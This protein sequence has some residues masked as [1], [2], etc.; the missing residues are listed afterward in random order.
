[1]YSSQ[2]LSSIVDAADVVTVDAHLHKKA[3]SS[4]G[5]PL[6]VQQLVDGNARTLLLRALLLNRSAPQA[7]LP[8]LRA[9]AV[10]LVRITQSHK[11]IVLVAGSAQDLL[12]TGLVQGSGYP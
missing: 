8:Y 3:L 12:G 9:A 6:C 2:E 11:S 4:H 10:A 7:H 1:M 5:T